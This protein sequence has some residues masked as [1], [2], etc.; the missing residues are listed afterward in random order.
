M[1]ARDRDPQPER[2]LLEQDLGAS[3]GQGGG[4]REGSVQ[5]P[6]VE[7]LL[8]RGETAARDRQDLGEE[9]LVRS[10]GGKDLGGAGWMESALERSSTFV[11]S[12]TTVTRIP[13]DRSSARAITRQGLLR[14]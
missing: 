10:S 12:S 4:V 9:R 13:L 5:F 11:R 2:V 3:L 8:E 6:E 14:R 7:P 1:P